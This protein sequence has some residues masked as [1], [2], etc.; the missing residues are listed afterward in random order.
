MSKGSTFHPEGD[1]EYRRRDGQPFDDSHLV[2][3]KKTYYN[4]ELPDGTLLYQ[5]VRYDDDDGR[6]G[7]DQRNKKFLIRRPVNPYF[8][9]A[10]N[11]GA[12]VF[13]VGER[14]VI[15]NWPGIVKLPPGS[16][17]SFCEGEKNADDL[18]KAGVPATTVISHKVTD[19]CAAALAGHHVLILEDHDEN[20]RK[21]ARAAQEKLSRFAKSTRIVPLVHLWRHLANEHA[22]KEPG[23]TTDVSDWLY[24]GGDPKKL[25]EICL[26]FPAE[27]EITA[28]PYDFP[29]EETLKPWD[30]LYGTHLL[31]GTVSGTAS[32]GG[33]GKSTLGIIE[34]LAMTSGKALVGI[35]PPRPLRVFLINLED[36]RNAV[37]KRIAA[38]MKHH[39]LTKTDIGERLFVRAKGELKIK[40]AKHGKSGSV[41]INESVIKALIDFV[42]E[43]KID[44]LTVDP[45]IR[46]HDVKENDNSE[47]AQVIEC[48]DTVAD[49]GD[50][51]VSLFHHTRKANGGEI[52]VESARGAQAFIDLCRAVRILET[53]SKGE[54]ERLKL[55]DHRWHFRSFNGKINFAPPMEQGTWYRFVNIKLNN[56]LLGGGDNVGVV[57]AWLHPGAIEPA[58]PS[59]AIITEIVNKVGQEKVW[60][61]YVTSNMWVGKVVAEVLQLDPEDDRPAIKKLL[62]YLIEI[63]ALSRVPGKVNCEP[64]M[65]VVAGENWSPE[66]GAPL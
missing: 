49:D 30:W 46:T 61:D 45:L 62:K 29:A 19:E 48:F 21:I 8:D 25:I 56:A 64:T 28:T 32:T 33:A 24:R 22:D 16:F 58:I 31:R 11:V 65:F 14:R 9:R 60:R 36:N 51:A 39:K 47:M 6:P 18:I 34:A 1:R 5:Q 2:G 7:V 57:E 12:C 4:Y 15:Y 52:T 27:G 43:N 3:Y 40:V 59:T 63:K 50:C 55:K 17:I 44:V 66:H 20:G 10:I 35:Q 13:G 38:A 23:E 37:D 53:M 54:G 26:K 42:R 41:W